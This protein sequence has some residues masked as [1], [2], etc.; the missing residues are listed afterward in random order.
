MKR[1]ASCVLLV[2]LLACSP[3]EEPAPT[4][5]AAAS[6]APP[7]AAP[8]TDEA[9]AIIGESAD[10]GDFQFTGVSWSAPLKKSAM[11][12]PTLANAREL[13]DAGWLRFSGDDLKLAA[14]AEGD[15][16]FLIRPNGFLDIVPL[17]KKELTSVAP[18]TLNP[19]GTA[20]SE[21]CFRWIAN[22]VGSS[23]RTGLLAE[24]LASEHCGIATL[25]RKQD[26]GWEV[27]LLSR[28]EDQ[29]P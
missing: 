29:T 24:R 27:L 8:T 12:E 28:R 16:R 26:G 10:F 15:K 23:F 22:E 21:F 4:T 25:Q 6:P 9:K 20:R 11:N 14:K 7:I 3:S 17:A 18:P 19:D 13:V 2:L 5:A 1:A